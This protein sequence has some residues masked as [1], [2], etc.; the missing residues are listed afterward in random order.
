MLPLTLHVAPR[1]K[2]EWSYTSA[3]PICHHGV[4]RYIFATTFM[5]YFI[6]VSVTNLLMFQ[7]SVLSHPEA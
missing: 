4:D 6:G 7:R 2:N 5:S 3:T 1:L